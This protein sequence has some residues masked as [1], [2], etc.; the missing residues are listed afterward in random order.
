MDATDAQPP[1]A[2]Q[3]FTLVEVLIASFLFA[4]GMVAAMAMQYTA[5]GGYTNARDL[6]NATDLSERVIELMKAESQQWR[7]GDPKAAI[8]SP[9]YATATD[10]KFMNTPLVATIDSSGSRTEWQSVFT[11]PVD[12]KM[13]TS[14]ARRFCAYVRGGELKDSSM[15]GGTGIFQIQVVVV[16]PGS[17][18]TFPGA[19]SSAPFGKCDKAVVKDHLNPPK[20][21]S[22]D[23]APLELNGY[24]GVYMGT[25]IVLRR[26]L[27][28]GAK[29]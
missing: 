5:L 6:T 19:G 18:K 2:Q 22:T 12:S 4:V 23:P 26:Y 28:T 1:A 7:Q 25:Q 16:Y 17:E 3:G 24:R 13:S 27:K 15:S 9:V 11:E 21:T 10:N 29:S 20:R 14:G 8:S